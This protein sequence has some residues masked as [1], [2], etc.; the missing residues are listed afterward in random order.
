LVPGA[1]ATIT[2]AN[3]DPITANNMVT[4]RGA[5]ATVLSGTATQLTIAV[6]CVAG[7]TPAVRVVNGAG[8]SATFPHPLVTTVRALTPGQ[9]FVTTASAASACNELTLPAGGSRYIVSVFSAGTSANSLVDFELHGNP[10]EP[11]Q[12][13]QVVRGAAAPSLSRVSVPGPEELRDRAHWQMLERNRADYETGMALMRQ[14]AP[15]AS[16]GCGARR[17]RT[18]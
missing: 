15:T 11:G 17:P 18:R 5:T 3:F 7:G 2:G 9:A 13:L 14:R 1:T 10:T 4:I 6:P 8:A 12:S 16:P